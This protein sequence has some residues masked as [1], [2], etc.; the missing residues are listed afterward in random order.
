MT[1]EQTAAGS[2]AGDVAGPPDDTGT[3]G[4]RDD[5]GTAGP[6]DETDEVTAAV[7]AAA[8]LLVGLSARALA[9]VGSALTLPQLRT[10]VVLDSS[11]PVKLAALAATLDVN[12]STAMRMVDRLEAGGLV[13]RKVNPEN[14]REVVL[15]TTGEGTALVGTVLE[16]RHREVAA[17][18]GRLPVDVRAGLVVGLRALTVA[19]ESPEPDRP[20]GAPDA[21]DVLTG[22]T[23][24]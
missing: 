10:L 7:M 18:V 2:P 13:D 3:A 17:L 20:P 12:A 21:R 11:G 4:P 22:G 15:R 19:A 1:G 16:H 8:R 9:E 6:P 14:R 23:G 24:F 5:T